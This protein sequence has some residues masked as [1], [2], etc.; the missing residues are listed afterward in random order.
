[1][2]IN[3]FNLASIFAFSLS[4]FVLIAGH[5]N[6]LHYYNLKTLNIPAKIANFI[7][8]KLFCAYALS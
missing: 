3:V 5:K 6:L 8:K 1:M 4:G 7:E 2:T